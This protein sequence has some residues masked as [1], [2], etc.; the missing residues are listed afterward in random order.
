M[1]QLQVVYELIYGLCFIR[2]NEVEDQYPETVKIAYPK[3][4]T[5]I[6]NVNLWL[7]NTEDQQL[8]LVDQP[9]FP[10]LGHSR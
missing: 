7:W 5:N 1:L 4:G 3:S 2:Y 9:Q 8:T 10:A 6:S